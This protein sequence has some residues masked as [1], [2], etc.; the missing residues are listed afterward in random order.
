[1]GSRMTVR[2][3]R[4][5]PP[6][7][8]GKL[9][10]QQRVFV[11]E[12]MADPAMSPSKAAERAGYAI[13]NVAAAKLLKNTHVAAFLKHK[14]KKREDKLEV[15]AE[16]VL[17]ELIDLGFRDIAGLFD[18]NGKLKNIHDIDPKLRKCIDGLKQRTKR[19][20]DKDQ[21]GWVEETETHL[22]L[23][24]KMQPLELIMKHMGM[25]TERK[26]IEHT[27]KV[28]LNWQEYYEATTKEDPIE[29]RISSVGKLPASAVEPSPV[30]D[31][32]DASYSVKELIEDEEDAED[33]A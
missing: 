14:Q 15:T 12:L 21:D 8:V 9:T 13:P 10:D 7:L 1:M 27:G 33:S 11:L 28:S 26:Q 3:E 23:V 20:F 24:R 5:L 18:D 4:K 16:D 22:D 19:Y 30:D 6:S 2:K 25:L 32:I 31:I 29:A 17:A